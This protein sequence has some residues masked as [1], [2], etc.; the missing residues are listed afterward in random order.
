LLESSTP[1]R[2][3][4]SDTALS[5]DYDYGSAHPGLDSMAPLRIDAPPPPVPLERHNHWLA[6]RSIPMFRRACPCCPSGVGMTPGPSDQQRA[7]PRRSMWA[8][9]AWCGDGLVPAALPR[10][11]LSSR[12]VSCYRSQF[13][14]A[15]PSGWS[16][17]CKPSLRRPGAPGPATASFVRACLS[18]VT[19]HHLG[20]TCVAVR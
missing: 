16:I 7:C 15:F 6:S 12:I 5:P 19:R 9:G 2:P 8:R 14:G 11:F 20:G 4:T 17:R 10:G 13:T 18:F 1:Q 3:H